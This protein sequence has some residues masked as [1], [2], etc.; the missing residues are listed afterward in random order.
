MKRSFAFVTLF[1]LCLS[2]GLAQESTTPVFI[3]S[4]SAAFVP[5]PATNGGSVTAG[6]LKLTFDRDWYSGPGAV[7]K[8]APA[9][10]LTPFK[11]PVAVARLSSSSVNTMSLN[12][13]TDHLEIS[14][15][16]NS[17]FHQGES[18]LVTGMTFNVRGVT[19]QSLTTAPIEVMLSADQGLTFTA[20]KIAVAMVV[21]S[22]WF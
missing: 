12:P 21:I 8:I 3:V 20:Q 9:N 10:G 6:L 14:I 2:V 11:G 22:F 5:D 16:N 17:A 19:P 18:I 1:V 15:P 13:Y 7:I 4:A